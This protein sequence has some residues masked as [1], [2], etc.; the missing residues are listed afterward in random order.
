[1]L[2]SA[3]RLGRVVV[4]TAAAASPFASHLALA[5][6]WTSAALPFAALQAVAAGVVLRGALPPGRLRAWTVLAPLCLL[7]AL[8]A[9]AWRSPAA[10]LLAAAGLWHG[11]LY[12]GLFILF[13]ASLAAGRTP[14]VTRLARRINPAFHPGME[15]YTRAVTIA[16]CLFFASQI[17]LSAVL[18][19]LARDAWQLLVTVL[20]VPLAVLMALAEYAVRRWRFRN[21]Q[22]AT[23]LA[24]I[25]GVRA[26]AAGQKPA[27]PGT[28]KV[29]TTKV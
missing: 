10:G 2:Q 28:T 15:G 18:L 24:M 6:G 26:G 20:S 23:L 9:G 13:A 17:V 21:Q 8:A 14:L 16:W 29:S 3:A 1:V 19:P 22:H 12:A 5:S 25:R 4:L 7:A 11:M 27:L